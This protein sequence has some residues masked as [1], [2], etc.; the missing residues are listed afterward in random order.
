MQKTD[1][2]DPEAVAQILNSPAAT[3]LRDALKR[4][5]GNTKIDPDVALRN[6][7]ERLR[8]LEQSD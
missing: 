5:A 2:V 4:M 7:C 1:N 8:R 6:W 3:E